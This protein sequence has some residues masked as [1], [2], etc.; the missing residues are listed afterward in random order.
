MNLEDN[1]LFLILDIFHLILRLIV[2][3]WINDNLEF[4]YE[5]NGLINIE[6]VKTLIIKSFEDII[7]LINEKTYVN[8]NH[9]LFLRNNFIKCLAK[10]Y[11][12]NYLLKKKKIM[13]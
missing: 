2:Q 13:I 5:D 12:D 7:R 4:E 9:Q 8:K 11:Y 10:I 1:K 6:K 3:F